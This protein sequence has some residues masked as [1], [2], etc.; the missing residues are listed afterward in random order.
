MNTGGGKTLIGVL[1][2]QSLVNEMAGSVVYVCPTIQLIEQAKMRAEECGLEVATYYEG[3]WSNEQ[4]FTGSYG[5]CLTN[6]AAVFNGKSI[7]R[8]KQ[9]AAFILDDA[10]VAGPSIRNAFT[11]RLSSG[12]PAFSKVVDLFKPYLEKSGHAQE[13]AAMLS[14]DGFPLYFIPGFELNRQ[15]Q[16]LTQILIDENVAE[17]KSTLFAWEHLRDHLKHC[18]VL[19]R[20]LESKFLPCRF[21]S[22]PSRILSRSPQDL[23]H[24]NH[25]LAR[26]VRANVRCWERAH[27][28][29]PG[30]KS[31]DSQRL[32]V[33][34][35][36]STDEEQRQ[37]AKDTIGSYKAC[38]ITP[39]KPQAN[40]WTDVADLYDGSSGQ[41]GVED[42]KA[43]PAPSKLVMAARY[44]G[45][46]LPGDACRVLVL[47]GIPLGSF[48]IDRFIDQTLNLAQTR[49][50]TTAIRLTQAIGRIF[51]SN[52]DHGVVVLCGT[53]L[54]SWLRNPKNQSFLPDLLQRQVQLGIQLREMVDAGDAGYEEFIEGVLTGD[55]EWD[56]IYKTSIGEYD[57][58]TR[59]TPAQWLIDAAN[60]EGLAFLPL[61]Q[62]DFA[63]A[64]RSIRNSC[65]FGSG[66]GQKI[67]CMVWT[68]VRVRPR[69]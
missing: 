46:D 64:S 17:T 52:T 38:V 10:H 31:G 55:R 51:R 27:V 16:K 54:Q 45:V 44:D 3:N 58:A 67:S 37:W 13:L 35:Q 39:S 28:I 26:S 34:A 4:V 48:A 68:L 42:F 69:R 7:F 61:W 57:I 20:R 66:F 24:R 50:G 59:T 56:R 19:F 23:S 41:Q 49:T 32:F 2:A 22:P 63:G 15:W 30:G 60:E 29:R 43:A 12:T 5:P 47:D 53:E 36:G 9:V 25:A 65:R 1:M 11:L 14:G 33:F 21:L 62:G 40:E 18:A 8:K 6:Y